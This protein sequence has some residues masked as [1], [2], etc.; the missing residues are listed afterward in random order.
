MSVALQN[1]TSYSISSCFFHSVF[2]NLSSCSYNTFLFNIL[3]W[4]T[5]PALL[6]IKFDTAQTCAITQTPAEHQYSGQ[7]SRRTNRIIREAIEIQLHPNNMD[8]ADGF[9]L[10]S[11]GKPLIHGMK[12]QKGEPTTDRAHTYLHPCSAHGPYEDLPWYCAP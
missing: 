8:R 3:Y 1:A 12:E 5:F 4:V 2:S 11:S 10:S 7:K 9:S 6:L